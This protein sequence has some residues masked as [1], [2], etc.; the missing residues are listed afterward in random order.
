MASVAV[1]THN[2]S[3]RRA[4]KDKNTF[5]QRNRTLL[6]NDSSIMAIDEY[7]QNY[8]YQAAPRM[9]A[10]PIGYHARAS[11]LP[12]GGLAGIESSDGA[13][14]GFTGDIGTPVIFKEQSLDQYLLGG[15]KSDKTHLDTLSR[16]I[17]RQH[18]GEQ[19]QSLMAPT[20]NSMN[21]AMRVFRN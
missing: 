8:A 14:M 15:V 13:S 6:N 18:T 3:P 11:T 20:A 19:R 9:S 7:Q 10:V 16:T 12:K 17:L 4:K 21:N 1:Y 2:P 5:A